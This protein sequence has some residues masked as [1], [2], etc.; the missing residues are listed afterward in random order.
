MKRVITYGTFDMFHIGHL[1]LLKRA[2]A[3]GDELYVGVSTDEFNKLKN[4]D[5]FIPY[6]DRVEIVKSIKY[7]DFV[8]PENSWEQKIEDIK[9][10][11][12]DI[13][14]MG[15]DWKEKFDYLQQYCQVIYLDRTDNIST[16]LLKDRLKKYLDINVENLKKLQYEV[17]KLIKH[18]E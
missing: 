15:S 7:V 1:N 17:D 6:E 10:Y 3:L 11:N 2:K 16:T 8:F 12:I 5:I 4:K 9:K 14:V 18:F 13:F